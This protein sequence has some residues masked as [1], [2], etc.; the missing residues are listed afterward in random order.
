ME[1]AVSEVEIHLI[2]DRVELWYVRGIEGHYFPTKP[3]A[4]RV[5][6]LS[7]PNETEDRRYARIFF[8]RFW[9]DS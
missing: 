3:V 5:A 4:E 2:D 1:L 6:R 9:R 8:H 7:F